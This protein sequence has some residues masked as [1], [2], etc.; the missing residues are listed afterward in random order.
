MGTFSC[1]K[2]PAYRIYSTIV[3]VEAAKMSPTV[4]MSGLSAHLQVT[5]H[6]GKKKNW[7]TAIETL[8]I[9]Y[10]NFIVSPVYRSLEFK[11]IPVRLLSVLLI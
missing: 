7:L 5:L 8:P 1:G 3:N 10:V 6:E 9:N 4:E 11:F 2:H